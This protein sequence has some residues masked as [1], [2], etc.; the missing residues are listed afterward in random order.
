M[1]ILIVLTGMQIG[2]LLALRWRAIDFVAGTIEIRESAFKNQFQTPRSDR[3]T[4]TIP[5]GPVV[6]VPNAGR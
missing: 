6:P 2:E 5:I 4:R 1:L 3:G